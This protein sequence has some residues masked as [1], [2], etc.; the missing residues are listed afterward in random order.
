MGFAASAAFQSYG[1]PDWLVGKK[2]FQLELQ[3]LP[4]VPDDFLSNPKSQFG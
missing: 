2:A 1:L 3:I 4:G